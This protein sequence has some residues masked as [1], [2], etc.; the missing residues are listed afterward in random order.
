TLHRER[1][2]KQI[3]KNITQ[4]VMEEFDTTTGQTREEIQQEVAQNGGIKKE[5]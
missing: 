2:E 5:E 1:I 4:K 3:A